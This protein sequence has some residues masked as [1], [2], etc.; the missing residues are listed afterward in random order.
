[1]SF[2]ITKVQLQNL[3]RWRIG[4]LVLMKVLCSSM[5]NVDSL[6]W[7]IV[8]NVLVTNS[9]KLMTKSRDFR[10]HCLII[11]KQPKRIKPLDKRLVPVKRR[12]LEA[13]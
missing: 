10:E 4:L 13:Y 9:P 3:R 8:K 5:N 6:A 1:M 7:G 11:G 2:N 12:D